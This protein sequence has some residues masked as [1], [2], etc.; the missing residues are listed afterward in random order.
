MFVYILVSVVFK[1]ECNG[2]IETVKSY[3]FEKG[4]DRCK[5]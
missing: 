1:F 3:E 4:R 5:Y 2:H